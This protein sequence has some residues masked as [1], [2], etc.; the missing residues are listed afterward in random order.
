MAAVTIQLARA[1]VTDGLTLGLAALSAFLLIRLRLNATWLVLGG[2][3]V[4]LL[5]WPPR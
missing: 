3:L 1:A 2:A 4:G 5:A